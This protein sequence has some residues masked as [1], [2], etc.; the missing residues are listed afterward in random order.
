M[1]NV[2]LLGDIYNEI[3]EELYN[4]KLSRA[5]RFEQQKQ[6]YFCIHDISAYTAIAN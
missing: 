4:E 1:K 5:S 3:S 6:I 2:F